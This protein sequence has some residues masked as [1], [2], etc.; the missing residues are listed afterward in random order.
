MVIMMRKEDIK[1]IIK[2]DIDSN[3]PN[4]P[5][6]MDYQKIANLRLVENEQAVVTKNT[7][8]PF[9]SF[10]LALS[11]LIIGVFA[12]GIWALIDRPTVT[13][14]LLPTG[15]EVLEEEKE[16]LTLSFL[17]NAALLPNDDSQTLVNPNLSN[18]QTIALYKQVVNNTSQI[19]PTERL[20]PFL[21]LIE[22]I[23]IGENKMEV[24]VLAPNNSEYKTR[25]QVKTKDLLGND[26]VYEMYYNVTDYQKDDEDES[27]FKIEGLIIKGNSEFKMIGEK[28]VEDNEQTIK[29]KTYINENK[30]IETVHETESDESEYFVRHVENGKTIYES[31]LEIEMETD[32][33][34]IELEIKS[35]TEI[36]KYEMEY[37]F[38]DG[39]PVIEIKFEIEE[40]TTNTKTEGEMKLYIT[41]DELTNISKYDILITIDGETYEEEHDRDFDDDDEDDDEKINYTSPS[42]IAL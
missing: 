16:V 18:T 10:R 35:A 3:I 29:M 31:K 20:K 36:S 13:P 15:V 19:S 26:I 30:Y 2:S 17:S 1:K 24:I 22:F 11:V 9:L 34:E 27:M 4:N 21:S 25:I 41:I 8:K 14:G 37:E 12:D 32:E 23:I 5:P 39:R 42:I 7:K 40:L 33:I 28:E 38:E 6:K